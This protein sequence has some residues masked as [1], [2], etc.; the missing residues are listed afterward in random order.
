MKRECT[1]NPETERKIGF[2]IWK[3]NGLRNRVGRE[4]RKGKDF[5]NERSRKRE[6][7]IEELNANEHANGKK[8]EMRKGE[9]VQ[10]NKTKNKPLSNF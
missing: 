2:E 10:G 1:R 4:F 8:D 7:M 5:E 6:R 3:R 9:C